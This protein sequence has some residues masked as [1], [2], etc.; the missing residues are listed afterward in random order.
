VADGED[1]PDDLDAL[2]NPLRIE[3]DEYEI[4][5]EV[6]LVAVRWSSSLGDARTTARV[7]VEHGLGATVAPAPGTGAAEGFEV[8]VLPDEAGRA[9]DVL[10]E[11]EGEGEDGGDGAADPGVEAPERPPVPWRTLAAIWVAAMIVLP[12]VAGLATYW[13]ATR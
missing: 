6:A 12:L 11:G 5:D 7:L 13:L 9:A 10:G 2:G 1:H 3:D 8:R 4:V